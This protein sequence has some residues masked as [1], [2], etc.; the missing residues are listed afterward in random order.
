MFMG[1]KSEFPFT[2]TYKGKVYGYS[3]F[4]KKR[5]EIDLNNTGTKSP[6]MSYLSEQVGL[7]KLKLFKMKKQMKLK[8]QKTKTKK[9]KAKT[10]T[11]ELIKIAAK[12]KIPPKSKRRQRRR[13]GED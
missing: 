6:L 5:G 12:I 8:K 13:R 9:P 7:M 3:Q 10:T 4:L 1:T 11:K 2:F